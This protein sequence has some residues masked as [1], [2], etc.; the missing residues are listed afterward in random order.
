MYFITVIKTISEPHIRKCIGY[1]LDFNDAHITVC[2]NR[3]DIYENKYEYAVIEYYKP[4][5][6]P[7]A[8][9]KW[10]YKYNNL[11]YIMIDVPVEFSDINNF[12]IGEEYNYGIE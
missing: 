5:L 2:E 9:R 1:K 11:F 12:A 10:F 6:Y 3:S 8:I 4:Y 7:L